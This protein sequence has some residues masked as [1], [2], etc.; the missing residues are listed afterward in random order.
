M[1][2]FLDLS[3]S[4][5]KSMLLSLCIYLSVCLSVSLS[6]S[7]SLPL[8]LSLYIY[9]YIYIC[10]YLPICLSLSD[11]LYHFPSLY[12]YCP[13]C[14]EGAKNTPT[15]SLQMA[16]TTPNES[17]EFDT[18]QSDGEA[19]VMLELWGMRSTPPLTL[20]WGLLWPR[21]EAPDKVL[22]RGEIEQNCLLIAKL[23][24]LK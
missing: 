3:I 15:A 1:S 11:Y 21:I 20:L 4:I 16:K 9:I 22:S 12:L 2:L 18:K 23:I 13:V 14:W 10:I 7:L 5:Y 6:L 24:Y 17:P 8:S 19:S